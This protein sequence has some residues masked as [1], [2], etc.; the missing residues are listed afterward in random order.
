[1]RRRNGELVD[2][3]VFRSVP[4]DWRYIEGAIVLECD[5]VAVLDASMWDLVDQLWA[6]LI[7]GVEE[8][9][10][11]RRFSTYFP[12]QPLKLTICHVGDGERL[13]TSTDGDD[14]KKAV[15]CKREFFAEVATR[16]RE[17]MA[18]LEKTLA[19][20]CDTSPYRDL[21]ERASRLLAQL[22]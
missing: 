22:E 3:R 21:H 19:H 2:Y 6:Y 16:G 4:E 18:W 11:A 20:S 17:Y 12:D 14:A 13:L 1:M 9:Q 8:L 5:G 10:S 7:A 15:V